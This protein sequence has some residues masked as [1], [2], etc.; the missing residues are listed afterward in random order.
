MGR[1]CCNFRLKLSPEN[2]NRIVNSH[3]VSF[4][5]QVVLP[6][7]YS[8]PCV[9]IEGPLKCVGSWVRPFLNKGF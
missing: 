8:G 1:L 3:L 2:A 5:P 7:W 9:G 6:A 4:E